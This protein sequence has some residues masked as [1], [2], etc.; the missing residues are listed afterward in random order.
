MLGEMV[1]GYEWCHDLAL[2]HPAP[3]SSYIRRLV[4]GAVRKYNVESETELFWGIL[5]FMLRKKSNERSSQEFVC[6]VYNCTILLDALS[7]YYQSAL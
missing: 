2:E 6:F 5:V 1:Y 7:H 3:L 4:F